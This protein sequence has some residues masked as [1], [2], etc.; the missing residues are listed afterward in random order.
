MGPHLQ[1]EG[2]D[3]SGSSAHDIRMT[4]TQRKKSPE[5]CPEC[6]SLEVVPIIYGYP[7]PEVMDAVMD[8]ARKGEIV[9]GGCVVGDRN[10]QKQ[11]KACGR[12]FDLRPLQ[13]TR[14][15]RLKK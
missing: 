11:C 5:T 15:P 9:V 10:P 14:R 8:A 4:K 7:G 2:L 1:P 12:K 13:A 3:L 6:G